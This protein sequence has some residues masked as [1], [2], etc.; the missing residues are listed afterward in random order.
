MNFR[1]LYLFLIAASWGCGTLFSQQISR[2]EYILTYKEIAIDQMERYGIPA[3]ICMAQAI[4]ESNNGNSRLAR[5]ANNHFGIKCRNEWKGETI[6]HDDDARNECFR[7]YESP[8]ESYADYAKF[9]DGSS[10]YDFLFDLQP[11]D[12]MGW[13]YGLKEAG[14]ATNPQYPELLIRII[15]ENNLHLLDQGVDVTYSDIKKERERITI[16]ETGARIDVDDYIVTID[17]SSGRQIRY[18][19]GT[20]YVIVERGDT[21]ASIAKDFRISVKKLLKYN[22]LPS[23]FALREGDALYVKK[24]S[25]RSENGYLTYVVREGDSMH[26][27]SQQFGIRLQNLYRINN[28]SVSDTIRSGQQ[29]RLR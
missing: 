19:N 18:N 22:D 5:E 13:A 25:K 4:L 2:E 28:M 27:I 12:Y 15:E 3:S 23:E 1:R 26:S 9:L 7:K 16:P 20:Q 11:N 17:K 21:F 29:I 24:K 8:Q 10:R 6:R 14:Y